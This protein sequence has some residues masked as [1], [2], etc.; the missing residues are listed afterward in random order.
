[1]SLFNS[2][3]PDI[4]SYQ[5]LILALYAFLAGWERAGLRASLMPAVPLLVG[6]MGAVNALGY[7]IPILITGDLFSIS[8]YKK[9]ADGKSIKKLIPFAAAGILAG[10]IAGQKISGS[11]FK[12]IIAV[13]VILSLVINLINRNLQKS[14]TEKKT[15]I[16]DCDNS[17][18]KKTGPLFSTVTGFVSMLGGSGGPVI[19]TYYLITG[20]KKNSFIG[21]TAW[22]FFLVNIIKTPL[23]F[24]IWKNISKAS[25]ITDLFMLPLLAAGIYSGVFIVKRINENVFR[26]IIYSVTF[27][28]A[29]KL[30]F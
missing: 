26:V 7:M 21:T 9:H 12:Q 18:L 5:L 30:F 25:L 24:F 23:Y 17:I 16:K 19:S 3:N 13:L 10:M 14:C 11:S 28:S 2:I 29:V 8:Y 15:G 27:L 20:V 1:M 4:N 22:F 6:S